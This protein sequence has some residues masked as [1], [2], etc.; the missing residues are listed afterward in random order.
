MISTITLIC[1]AYYSCD[2]SKELADAL[3]DAKQWYRIRGYDDLN[4]YDYDSEIVSFMV[5]DY[6]MG[7][8]NKFEKPIAER[9]IQSLIK[10]K[11]EVAYEIIP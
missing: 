5:Q 3:Y 6:F 4:R 9:I 8:L 2:I 1:S 10:S 7:N 11:K